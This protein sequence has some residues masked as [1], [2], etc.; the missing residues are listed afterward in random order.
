M[1]ILVMILG[2]AALA[3]YDLA[4]NQSGQ[5]AATAIK[6][7]ALG[8]K[9]RMPPLRIQDAKIGD[10]GYACFVA[11]IAGRLYVQRIDDLRPKPGWCRIHIRRV[12]SG[13]LLEPNSDITAVHRE[14]DESDMKWYLPVV[15][16]LRSTK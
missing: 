8:I 7:D 12:P 9:V 6:A 13:V 16:I 5:A 11:E 3:A 14:R 2:L 1:K 4:A 10:E 15:G